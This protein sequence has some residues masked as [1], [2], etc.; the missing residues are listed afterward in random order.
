M[1]SSYA[2]LVHSSMWW[3]WWKSKMQHS[4]K[5]FDSSGFSHTYWYN[6]HGLSHF[7]NWHRCKVEIWMHI[8]PLGLFNF[9]WNAAL[10]GITSVNLLCVKVPVYWC[11]NWEGLI[12]YDHLFQHTNTQL[13]DAQLGTKQLVNVS[14]F[15]SILLPCFEI[16][17]CDK[18]VTCTD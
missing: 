16:C 17:R 14:A 7:V 15:I 2:F 11:S 5:H 18:H 1:P 9:W 3:F 6:K 4:L 13:M 10:W 8:C 12:I